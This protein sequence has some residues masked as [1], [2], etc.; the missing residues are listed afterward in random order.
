MKI[1]SFAPDENK[2]LYEATAAATTTIISPPLIG[3]NAT[4]DKRTI[5]PNTLYI[6][7]IKEDKN[8][9]IEIAKTWFFNG[10]QQVDNLSL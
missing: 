1:V 3:T 6:Y 10:F 5:T 8:Y 9:F 2:I 4:E 7:D